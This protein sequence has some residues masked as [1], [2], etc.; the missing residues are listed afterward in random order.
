MEDESNGRFEWKKCCWKTTIFY[1]YSMC[2]FLIFFTADTYFSY[3]EEYE[4]KFNLLLA[5]AVFHA[6]LCLAHLS[7]VL[8]LRVKCRRC[9]SWL[10]RPIREP[11]PD[12][13]Y[14]AVATYR[15]S[16][17]AW[18]VGFEREGRTIG[19][20]PS[21]RSTFSTLGNICQ[22]PDG[23][24]NFVDGVDSASS[25]EGSGRG[26]RISFTDSGSVTLPSM[27]SSPSAES[28]VGSNRA[29]EE[30]VRVFG[31]KQPGSTKFCKQS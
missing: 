5:F 2:F 29:V 16:T 14:R 1:L 28:P 25:K 12:H 11:S 30:C 19:L 22:Q 23:A 9:I 6:V 4:L 17:G 24:S 10:I 21:P 20:Q 26:E 27:S 13:D 8:S 18:D 31:Q 15:G 3:K 7:K